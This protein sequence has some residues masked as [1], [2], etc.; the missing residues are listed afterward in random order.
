MMPDIKLTDRV[1][2]SRQFLQST[3]I[4]TGEI[5]FAKGTVVAIQTFIDIP[6]IAM[7]DWNVPGLPRKVLLKNLHK[8][9]MAEAA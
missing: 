2:Y 4:C 8:V 3:G 5:P 7:V 6:A 1:Q 9:G